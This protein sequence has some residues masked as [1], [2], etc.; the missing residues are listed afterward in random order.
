MPRFFQ[1]LLAILLLSSAVTS[2]ADSDVESLQSLLNKGDY[3]SVISQIKDIDKKTIEHFQLLIAAYAE[4]DLDDA[5]DAAE[6]AIEAFPNEYE[7]YLQHAS[8]MGAQASDSVFSA[9][10]YA[11]KALNSLNKAV[12]LAPENATTLSALMTFYIAAPSIAGGDLEEAQKL[13]LRIKEVDPTEGQFAEARFLRSDD[14][15]EEAEAL[16]LELAQDSNAESHASFRAFRELGNLY[17]AQEDYD[18]A[19]TY[20]Q[21]ASDVE[22]AKPPLDADEEASD[23]Y[24]SMLSQQAY[25]TYA[26]GR[27]AI[28]S[29]SH[30]Q[31]GVAALTRYISIIENAQYSIAGLPSADWAKLRMTELQLNMDDGEGATATFDSI[32]VEND[33]N[34]EKIYKKLKRKL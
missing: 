21:K 18:K 33:K 19:I 22:I 4:K 8:I 5:E 25:A 1:Y 30:N 24:E 12:E 31:E 29:K 13:V 14:K 27:T 34:F 7:V 3:A 15:P 17:S 32:E 9:L 23:E 10:G 6:Q 26:I 28:E 2:V 11:K 16:L 20:L